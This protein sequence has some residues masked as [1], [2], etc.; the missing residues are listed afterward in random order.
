MEI[1]ATTRRW[2]NSIGI[3]LPKDLLQK[4][5]IQENQKVIIDIKKVADIRKLRG[6]VSFKRNAQQIKDEMREGWE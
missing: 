6:L 2:G 4:E 1:E 3:T 5:K